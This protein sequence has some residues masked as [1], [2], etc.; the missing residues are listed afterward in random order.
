M[1]RLAGEG[2]GLLQQIQ[3]DINRELALQGGDW[4]RGQF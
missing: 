1:E 2:L 3:G 4:I